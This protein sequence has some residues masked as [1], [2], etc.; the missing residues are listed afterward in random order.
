MSIASPFKAL[1]LMAL[2]GTAIVSTQAFSSQSR[3]EQPVIRSPQE[4]VAHSTQAA[5]A[6]E[7]PAQACRPK[8]RVA[9]AGY[10]EAE[11]LACPAPHQN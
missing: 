10:G 8:V 4:T 11:R 5:K 2:F 9:Y 3:V 6:S 7:M 1:S